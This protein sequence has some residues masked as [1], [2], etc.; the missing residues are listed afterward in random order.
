[1]FDE[2][3]IRNID[4][5]EKLF[6]ENKTNF[7]RKMLANSTLYYCCG[8]DITPIVALSDKCS[9]FVYADIIEYGEG[10]F[11][12]ELHEMHQ[13]LYER[14]F[15]LKSKKQF[16]EPRCRKNTEISE[17]A[18]DKGK[19]F[20][21]LYVQCDASVLF[22]ILYSEKINFIQPRCICN[23]RNEF[24]DGINTL[25]DI[26]KRTEMIL[27]HCTNEKYEMVAEYP[28]YG[29]YGTGIKIPLYKRMYWYV[30]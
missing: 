26:E 28:Y 7:E 25:I 10:D 6:K 3:N 13:R 1:M 15:V 27:G 19:V 23:Y 2:V 24:V 17:W 18:T 9:L 8:K 4:D 29:D 22:R 16:V 21:I 30:Y 5:V 20:Y 11:C 14:G 12:S